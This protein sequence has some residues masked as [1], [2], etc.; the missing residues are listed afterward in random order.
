[1]ECKG[2]CRHCSCCWFVI[3]AV[4]VVVMVSI[5]FVIVVVDV[6]I[7]MHHNTWYPYC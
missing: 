1:M 6:S 2:H 5:A 4:D 3:V 7:Y